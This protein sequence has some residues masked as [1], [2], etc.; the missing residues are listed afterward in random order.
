MILPAIKNFYYKYLNNLDKIEKNKFDRK[1]R[2]ALEIQYNSC[3][4]GN[5]GMNLDDGKYVTTKFWT[6]YFASKRKAEKKN[7]R[8]RTDTKLPGISPNN[9]DVNSTD[10]SSGIATQG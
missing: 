1:V 7:V 2:E 9:T 6:P 4:P 10:V 5:G 8:Q 3:G